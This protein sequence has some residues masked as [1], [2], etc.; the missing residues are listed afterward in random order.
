MLSLKMC[1]HCI[2]CMQSI[3]MFLLV[4]Y[5]YTPQ[6]LI[7][8]TVIFIVLKR[9]YIVFCACRY[10][11]MFLL[12]QYSYTLRRLIKFLQQFI[13]Y[14]SQLLLISLLCEPIIMLILVNQTHRMWQTL[15]CCSVL[16]VSTCSSSFLVVTLSTANLELTS[17]WSDS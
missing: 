3:C 10:I 16:S 8:Y 11:C 6:R 14:F 4:Q 1:T 9:T 2:S 13:T 12:V 15:F 7:K 17:F 5:S